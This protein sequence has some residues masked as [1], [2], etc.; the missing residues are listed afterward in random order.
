MYRFG[1]EIFWGQIK[2][3]TSLRAGGGETEARAKKDQQRSLVFPTH[4][5]SRGGRGGEGEGQMSDSV[6]CLL[7]KHWIF[8]S[9]HT[10]IQTRTRSRRRSWQR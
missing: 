2:K 3:K 6:S 5:G 9:E 7:H 8:I 1:G 10:Q 4:P